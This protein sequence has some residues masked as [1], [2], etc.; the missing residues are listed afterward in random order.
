MRTYV[1]R[2]PVRIDLSGGTIDLWPIHLT[3]PEPGVTVN[4]ALDVP[5]TVRVRRRE[6]GVVRVAS[7]DAHAE[8]TYTS[9][10]ELRSRVGRHRGPLPLHARA[11]AAAWDE[12]GVDVVSEAT[13]PQ[14]AGLGGSSALLATLVSVLAAARGAPL[15]ADSALNLSQDLETAVVAAPTGYQDYYP[16]LL[17]GCLALEGAPGGVRVERLPV[18]LAALAR[19]LRLVYTGAP[20]RSGFTNWSMMR[21]YFDGEPATVSALHEIAEIS[22]DVRK[23]L[24]H[25]ELDEALRAVVTEGAVRRRIAPGVTTEMIDSLDAAVRAAGAL[26]TKILGAGGGGCVLV[27]LRD[28]REPAGLSNALSTGGGRPM[29]LRLPADGLVVREEEA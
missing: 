16:P 4:V 8:E 19:R 27:V 22:R 23:S 21:A 24:R 26:G 20:H 29:P 18:D 5:V 3:L 7:I 12:T 17:G 10:A 28:D 11:V 13:S 1:G 9:A 25:G 6:D 15:D 2:A 14:G